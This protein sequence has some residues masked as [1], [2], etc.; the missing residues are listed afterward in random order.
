VVAPPSRRATGLLLAAIVAVAFLVR[1]AAVLAID[2]DP[3]VGWQFDM[4][5]YD[6]VARRLLKGWG[7]IGVDGAPTAAWPPGYPLFLATIYALFGPSLLAAK[8]ANALLGAATAFVTYL[9]ACE[10]RRPAVGLVAAAVLALFPG[11]VLFSPAIL[12][13]PLFGFLSCVALWLFIR[14]DRRGRAGAATWAGLGLFLGA[15]S[16]VRGVGFL[17]LPVFASTRLF[18]GASWRSTAR[19]TLAAAAGIAL[20]LAPWTLRNDVRLGYPILIGTD[21]AFALYVG[22]SPIATGGHTLD[23]RDPLQARFGELLALPAPRAEVEVA[24]AQIREA[25]GWMATHP[26]RVLA[27]VP[28]KL[29]YMYRDDRGARSWIRHGLASRFSPDAERWLF[30]IVDGYWFAVL[31][32]ALVGARRFLPR[33]GPGAVAV[34]LT[35]AWMTAVHAVFFFGSPRFHVPLVP[36]L[37]LLAAAEIVAGAQRLRW[38]TT[39]RTA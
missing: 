39:P 17:L 35:V 36:V 19:L 21:G 23:M 32:L 31:G 2:V 25:L 14:C 18:E 20:A 8:V 11:H 7:Y 26:H 3:R 15:I 6:G 22:N 24:R 16:L 1:L 28:A 9:I 34:P 29:Y 13:E 12:S 38:G 33:D 37:S 30:R 5:W 4:S 10:L 27:L